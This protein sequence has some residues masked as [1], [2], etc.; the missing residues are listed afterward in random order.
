[1]DQS[2]PSIVQAKTAIKVKNPARR[3]QLRIAVIFTLIII[4]AALGAYFLL[5]GSGDKYALKNYNTAIA[6]TGEINY[7]AQG[8]GAVEIINQF[9]LQSPENGYAENLYVSEGETVK[10]GAVLAEFSVPDLRKELADE[11]ESLEEN[12]LNLEKF[13]IQ[14]DN[15]VAKAKR[16]I[17]KKE[18]DITTARND[19]SQTESLFKSGG[20]S[21]N[22]VDQKRD[23]LDALISDLEEAK[24]SLEETITL[25][26]IDLKIKEAAVNDLEESITELEDRIAAARITSPMD[27]DILSMES[28]LAVPGSKITSGKELFIIGQPES[29]LALVEVDEEFAA[30]LGIDGEARLSVGGSWSSGKITSIGKVAILSSDGVTATVEVK[31]KPDRL[32]SSFIQGAAVTAEFPL[33]SRENVLQ[34]PR[35]AYLTTGNQKYVYVI[36]GNKAYRKPVEYGEIQDLTIEVLSGL[37][38]GEKIITS[39][40]SNFIEY[41]EI[42]LQ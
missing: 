42:D 23:S 31:I 12:L 5:N 19:L 27:G 11:K 14:N 40:Y 24:I 35:G 16:D 10:T 2:K 37:N 41:E 20:A 3:R 6:E 28:S 25:Y 34:L 26:N 9:I 21:K 17:A 33:G 29:A 32:T 39:S 4:A 36:K 8:S 18:K 38:P 15:S 7:I 22:D 13:K 1:M 30:Q